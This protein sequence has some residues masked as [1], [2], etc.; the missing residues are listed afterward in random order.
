MKDFLDPGSP[1][2]SR[3]TT[4]SLDSLTMNVVALLR[5]LQEPDSVEIINSLIAAQ[6]QWEALVEEKG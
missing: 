1:N 3:N 5:L 4:T 2:E 6:R